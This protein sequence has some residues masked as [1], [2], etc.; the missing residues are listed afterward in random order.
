MREIL[1][2]LDDVWTECQVTSKSNKLARDPLRGKLNKIKDSI[3]F[4]NG[5][6]QAQP[7]SDVSSSVRE[8]Q[9]RRRSSRSVNAS[10]VHGFDD[11]VISLEKV[12]LRPGSEGRFKA[13]GIT[14]IAGIGKTTLCQSLFSKKE[15]KDYFFPRIW[16]CMSAQTGDDEDEKVAILK[17]MLVCLG[18]EDEII[19]NYYGHNN[20]KELLY[21]LHLQLQGKRY[22]IVF[23]DVR[24]GEIDKWYEELSCSSTW[25]GKWDALAYGLPKGCGGAVIVTSRNEEIAK[26]MVGGEGN[27]HRL[28]PL[29]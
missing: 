15:V 26:K 5:N 7:N 14:G 28:L 8:N 19:D 21:A 11:D 6:A 2:S 17:R 10:N 16:V 4:S 25:D 22:L 27:L 20:L 13:I 1:Y 12:L 24:G 29:C 9:V 18:V 3:R 23:D